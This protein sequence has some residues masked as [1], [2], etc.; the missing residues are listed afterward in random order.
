M[1]PY[2]TA[3][4]SPDRQFHRC[5]FDDGEMIVSDGVPCVWAPGAEG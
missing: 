1:V 3:R 5:D 4:P 2:G